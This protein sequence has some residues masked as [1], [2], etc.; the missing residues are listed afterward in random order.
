MTT[1][2]T[3]ILASVGLV[4]CALYSRKHRLAERTKVLD[5]RERELCALN[6]ET[7]K[8]HAVVA[9]RNRRLDAREA[10]LAAREQMI[11]LLRAI[12][13]TGDERDHGLYVLVAQSEGMVSPSVQSRN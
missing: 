6:D 4:A 9:Q 1:L 3:L 13:D 11:P 2:T 8:F 10:A 5:A 7:L 12:H